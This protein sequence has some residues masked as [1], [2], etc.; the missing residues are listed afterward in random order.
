[1]LFNLQKRGFKMAKTRVKSADYIEELEHIRNQNDGRL[2]AR[3][4]V[5]FARNPETALHSKFEW[6]DTKAAEAYRLQTARQIIKVAVVVSPVNS[7]DMIST[8]VSLKDDRKQGTGYR[9]TVEVLSDE[10]LTQKRINDAI[11]E[12]KTFVKKY[13]DLKEREELQKVFDAIN[14]L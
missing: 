3:D 2:L 14:A 7:N 10:S 12:L 4:V 1:M 13:S 8:Y 5:D 6:D 11:D 9:T